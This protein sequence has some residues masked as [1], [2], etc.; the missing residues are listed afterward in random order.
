MRYEPVRRVAALGESTTWGYSVSDK[1]KC[2][3]NQVVAML[4]EFQGSEIVLINQ[5]IGSNVLTSAC[6]AYEFSAKPSA[7]DRVDGDLIAYNPDMVFLSY[8][9]NDS[10]GGTP[11]ETFRLSYQ[12]LINR[13]RDRIDPVIVLVNT[14]Y[15][16][17]VLY[18]NCENWE[19]SSYELTEI[20]NL[21]IQQLAEKNNLIL[22]DVYAAEIGVDWII[23]Q[24]HCHPN[25]LGHRLIANRVFEAIVRNCSFVARQMPTTTLIQSFVEKYGNGPDSPSD[26]SITAD[27]MLKKVAEK[28]E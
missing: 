24:D 5:G 3:V 12:E 4:E 20:Y 10:R 9:L 7:L 26:S 17:E 13:I 11:P 1:S 6:P 27:V 28:K 2:W 8:G 19:E 15:M 22:A 18:K 21:V 25:D 14:Y 23:D 16:H